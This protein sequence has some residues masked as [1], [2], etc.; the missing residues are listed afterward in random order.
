MSD[1]PLSLLATF[2]KGMFTYMTQQKVFTPEVI[3]STI[4]SKKRGYAVTNCVNPHQNEMKYW[5][6]SFELFPEILY[7]VA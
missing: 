1:Q 5:S 7:Y 2:Y 3:Y 6:T 4:G